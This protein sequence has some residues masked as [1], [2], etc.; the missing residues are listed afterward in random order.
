MASARAAAREALDDIEAHAGTYGTEV[1]VEIR[2][3]LE[4]LGRALEAV[5]DA[6]RE[7]RESVARTG[8]G[9]LRQ[10]TAGALI[11]MAERIDPRTRR[12]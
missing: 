10:A 1:V 8:V 11:G 5:G 7:T 6:R 12:T 2:A 4:H 3:A 9:L